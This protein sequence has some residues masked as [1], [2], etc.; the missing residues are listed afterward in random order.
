MPVASNIV[1][2]DA[3]PTARTFTPIQ[4]GP[5]R[6]VLIEKNVALTAAGMCT[7]VLDFSMANSKRKTDRVAVRCNVPIERTDS[8]SGL[9]S[10]V[11]VARYEGTWVNPDM[12]TVAER[13]NVE[14]MVRN[15]V[16]HTIVQGYVKS[17]DPFYG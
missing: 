8:T 16:S 15:L 5:A 3:V 9:T 1:I 12:L 13:N 7:I 14:A 17:R 11:G 4:V 6:S 10:V 2:N